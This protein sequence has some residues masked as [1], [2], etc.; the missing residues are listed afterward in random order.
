[1]SAP[2]R[3]TPRDFVKKKQRGER[4]VMITAYSYPQA[5]IV[6]AAGVDG[7]LVGDSVAMV[8]LGLPATI[9][10]SMKE[11]LHHVRAV[12]RARPRALVVG[13]MPFMSYERSRSEALRNAAAFI[14]AGA[15]AVKLEGGAEVADRVEALVKAGIPVM[16]HVG[17]TPQRFLTIGGYRLMGKKAEQ[18]AK[19]LEDA[20]AREDAGAFAVVIENTVAEV[21]A[22]ITKRLRIPTICIGSGPWCDGQIIVLHDIVGLTEEPPYFTRR[23]ADVASVMRRAVESY[24]EDVRSGRFPGEGMYRR[25]KPEELE[26]FRKL[27]RELDR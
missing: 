25:M 14:R 18:A 2:R 23:Y 19:L 3:V 4:I 12:A 8:E 21:A 6:D 16:G 13:D 11:M 1:M 10:V 5:R 7:I 15:D 27:L 24:V 17:L 26:A 20:K 22:E 9:Y